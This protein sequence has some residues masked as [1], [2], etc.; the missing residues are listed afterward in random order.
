[1]EF[2][3]I[4]HILLFWEVHYLYFLRR[5]GDSSASI[6]TVEAEDTFSPNFGA[7]LQYCMMSSHRAARWKSAQPLKAQIFITDL[8]ERCCRNQACHPARHL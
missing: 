3:K 6:F 5:F 2:L 1:M 7:L 4:S 8:L